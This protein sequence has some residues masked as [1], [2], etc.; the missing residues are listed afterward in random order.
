VTLRKKVGQQ[1]HLKQNCLYENNSLM[2]QFIVAEYINAS[3]EIDSI[4]ACLPETHRGTMDNLK[5]SL[6]IL[7]GSLQEYMR[8]FS[9]NLEEGILS[10]LKI[11]AALFVANAE[12]LH[13]K[14]LQLEKYSN[15]A[16]KSSL[17][18]L[19]IMRLIQ[20][21]QSDL[22]LYES[23]HERLNYLTT[24][25]KKL[26]RLLAE[27]ILE[28]SLDE[29][30]LFFVLRYK[31][32]LDTIYGVGF[33]KRLFLKMYPEGIT[34]AEKYLKHKYAKRGFNNLLLVITSKFSELA[35][36]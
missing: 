34:E 9:W 30:V 26:G 25:F 5:K 14:S 29:N 33:V 21:Q 2:F 8:F 6:E 36:I 27:L 19:E 32:K 31:E 24:I 11:Y 35:L 7:S 28:F 20:N 1:K 23:L 17:E 18:S 13:S 12:I 10:K 16:W 22:S 15:L 3:T 4:T